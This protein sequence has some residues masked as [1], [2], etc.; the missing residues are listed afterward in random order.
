MAQIYPRNTPIHVRILADEVT[1]VQPKS[2]QDDTTS[3]AELIVIFT[4]QNRAPRFGSDSDEPETG[5]RKRGKRR[6]TE[7][8]LEGYIDENS[9]GG[10]IVEWKTGD[11]SAQIFD[12]D[13]ALNGTVTLSLLHSNPV[14]EIFRIEPE[15]VYHNSSFFL[16]VNTTQLPANESVLDYEKNKNFTLTV[17]YS[18]NFH[19]KMTR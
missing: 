17:S 4:N 8:K 15:T 1:T 5:R 12:Y 14:T 2:A 3:I 10:A 18:W 19:A 13:E 11:V 9:L 7:R 16:V 6:G